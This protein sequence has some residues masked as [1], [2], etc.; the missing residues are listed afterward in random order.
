MQPYL[1]IAIHAGS[2][3]I[4]VGSWNSFNTGSD[5]DLGSR[6]VHAWYESDIY[7]I[8]TFTAGKTTPGVQW[9]S[10]TSPNNDYKTVNELAFFMGFDDSKNA[11]P[12]SPKILVGFETTDGQADAGA[13]KGV[14]LELSAK[15][16]TKLGSKATLNIPVKLGMSLKDYYELYDRNTLTF[17]D[18]KFG[19][20]DIG[21]NVSVPVGP[22]EVHGGVD[23]YTFGTTT[24][25]LNNGKR[26]EAVGSVGFSVGF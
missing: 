25:A 17:T 4:D 7:G 21:A 8:A 22:G 16:S 1:D 19:Y 26:N 6:G 12:V 13:N 14:Y 10:Y 15:P 3:T 2:T 23:V 11:V 5:K 20:F 24:K 9:T 18:N